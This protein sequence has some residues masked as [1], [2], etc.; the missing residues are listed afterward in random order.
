MQLLIRMADREL[1]ERLRL[2]GR[3]RVS[4]RREE[5]V[6]DT[7]RHVLRET[8]YRTPVDQAEARGSWV[9]PLQLAGGDVPSGW[10]GAHPHAESIRSG[11]EKSHME[12]IQNEWQ[13]EIRCSSEVPH[14]VYL[15]YGTR[16]MPATTAVRRSLIAGAERVRM[17]EFLTSGIMQ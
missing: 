12:R 8:I 6:L 3:H 13:S 16:H 15:E 9:R 2:L 10:E 17:E 5:I 14:V 1:V 4:S 7:T 11:M